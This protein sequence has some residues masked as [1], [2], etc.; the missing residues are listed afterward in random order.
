ML[1]DDHPLLKL[2]KDGLLRRWED[3]EYELLNATPASSRHEAQI[4][5]ALGHE[6]HDVLHALYHYDV[7][8][9]KASRYD[10]LAA[11][12]SRACNGRLSA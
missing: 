7:D 8:M 12:C 2:G 1:N 9:T 5:Q 11:A 3:I 4:Y 6:A 10:R